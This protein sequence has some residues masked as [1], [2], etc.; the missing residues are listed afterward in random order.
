M[1][2][3]TKLSMNPMQ[4]QKINYAIFLMLE[5]NQSSGLDSSWQLNKPVE[6]LEG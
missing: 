2:E 5:R 4:F 6:N 1:K 3:S